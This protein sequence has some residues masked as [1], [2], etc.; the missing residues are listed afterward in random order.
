MQLW[1]SVKKCIMYPVSFAWDF[2][3]QVG[4]EALEWDT[5]QVA[6][7]MHDIGCQPE[8]TSNVEKHE[9]SKT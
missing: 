5:I 9:A 8:V 1:Y 2:V 6:M 4:Y 7:W 3:V